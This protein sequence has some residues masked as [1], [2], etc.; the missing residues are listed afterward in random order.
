MATLL[1]FVM[2][3]KTISLSEL[4]ADRALATDV[5]KSLISYGILDPP[6]DGKFGPVSNWAL[7]EFAA[8]RPY[9]LKAGFTPHLSKL[10]LGPES[11]PFYRHA[12]LAGRIA[13]CMNQY[14]YW[15]NRHPDC[16]NIV[17][18][19]GMNIVDGTRNDN[20]PNEFNDF[21]CLLTIDRHGKPQLAGIWKATTEPQILDATSYKIQK[22]PPALRLVNTKHG[23]WARITIMKLCCKWRA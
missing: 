2:G 15:I 22:G 5:Q 6:A 1:E 11:C 12:D 10:L 20:K 13:A 7:A 14:N 21:R 3:S 17:Y 18:I 16:Y 19:E 9:D 4:S 23:A 8:S